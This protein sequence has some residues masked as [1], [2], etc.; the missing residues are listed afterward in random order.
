MLRPV[1]LAALTRLA[2][3]GR[4]MMP[5]PMNATVAAVCTGWL[6]I[7]Q[8]RRGEDAAIPPSPRRRSPAAV[9][10]SGAYSRPTHPW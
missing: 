4:P 7:R 3:M 2:A 8:A 1:V 6:S 5:R 10:P 9:V